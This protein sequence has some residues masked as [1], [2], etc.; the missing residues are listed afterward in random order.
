MGLVLHNLK[1]VEAGLKG[2]R[3][4]ADLTVGEDG[5]GE[6]LTT[7]LPAQ[8][9]SEGKNDG[10]ATDNNGWQDKAEFEREQGIEQGEVGE[11]N[12]AVGGRADGISVPKVG[13]EG[14][15]VDLDKEARKRKKKERRLQVRKESTAKKLKEKNLED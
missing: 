10:A 3:L 7:E 14:A 9:P 4:A 5:E 12:K 2:E 6:F 8:G 1:R 11:R 15:K 13:V